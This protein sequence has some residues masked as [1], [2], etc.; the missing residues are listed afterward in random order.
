MGFVIS[1]LIFSKLAFVLYEDGICLGRTIPKGG[2]VSRCC[3]FEGNVS[4]SP[5]E[6]KYD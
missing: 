6:K 1:P 5:E 2:K 4:I 3:I